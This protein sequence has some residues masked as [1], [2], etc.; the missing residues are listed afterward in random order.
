MTDPGNWVGIV[1]ACVGIGGAIVAWLTKRTPDA[2]K[3]QRHL[4]D[5]IGK[6]ETSERE[7]AAEN[8]VLREQLHAVNVKLV[9]LEDLAADR[10]REIEQ[11]KRE[12]TEE[13]IRLKREVNDVSMR[14]GEPARYTV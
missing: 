3:F 5:R 12:F 7:I 10:L 2:T 8:R 4:F 14:H 11:I 6:I 9:Q 1:G 13:I